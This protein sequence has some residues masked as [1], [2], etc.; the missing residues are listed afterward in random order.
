MS[1]PVNLRVPILP[2]G[3][4]IALLVATGA[5]SAQAASGAMSGGANTASMQ[6]AAKVSSADKSFVEKAAIGSMAEVQMGRLAQQKAGSDQVKQFGTR[7]VDDHS[8]ANDDLKQVASHKGITL[9]SDLD[10]KHKNKMAKLEKLSGAQFDRAY[11]DD[12]VAD[13]KED[14]AEFQK[15]SSSGKDGDLKGFAS[16][17]LPTLQDH[18]KMA[19]STQAA[20]RNGGKTNA[21]SG[22]SST[23]GG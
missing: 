22:R 19:Q 11:M 14:V 8:K 9:P 15:Q 16:K 17:T 21:S 18:L 20:V 13:H 5:A 4:G 12:M 6:S 2:V 3:V 10:A 7:M 1:H 23:S